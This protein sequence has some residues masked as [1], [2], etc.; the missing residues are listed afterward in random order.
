MMAPNFARWPAMIRAPLSSQRRSDARWFQCSWCDA[1]AGICHGCDRGH[2]Y[3]SHACRREAR[4]AAQ[5]EASRCYQSTE[6]GRAKHAARSARYRR[7]QR[8]SAAEPGV[9]QQG[10]VFPGAECRLL[11][12]PSSECCMVCSAPLQ[13]GKSRRAVALRARRA[14]LWTTRPPTESLSWS[15]T[16]WSCATRICVCARRA[17][18]VVCWRAW[19]R[20]ASSCPWWRSRRRSRAATA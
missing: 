10:L 8:E 19:S 11:T 14:A 3:C 6:V 18:K 17:W 4:L 7:R 16:S 12:P 13:G 1:T 9:T 20:T 5:R 2:K 15:T